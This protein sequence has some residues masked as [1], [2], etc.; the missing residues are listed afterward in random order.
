[1]KGDVDPASIRSNTFTMERPPR[2]GRMQE[3]PEVDRAEFFRLEDARIR[4]NT[5]QVAFLDQLSHGVGA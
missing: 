4:I 3:S 1:V 2:S 5:A